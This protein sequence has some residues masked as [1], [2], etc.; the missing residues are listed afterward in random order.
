MAP[1]GGALSSTAGGT[2]SAPKQTK[3]S[4]RTQEMHLKRFMAIYIG[5]A[6]AAQKVEWS[7]SD[8]DQIADMQARRGCGDH[9]DSSDA[10]CALKRLGGR[11]TLR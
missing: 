10:W 5:S 11:L 2:R 3:T 4:V 9:G 7:K 6:T 1:V 8:P